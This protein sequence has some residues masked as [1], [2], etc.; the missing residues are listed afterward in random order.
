MPETMTQRLLQLQ[1][2]DEIEVP[3]TRLDRKRVQNRV[4]GIAQYIRQTRD[5]SFRIC[6]WGTTAGVGVERVS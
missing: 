6:T 3:C 5:A 4:H 2:D 1:G